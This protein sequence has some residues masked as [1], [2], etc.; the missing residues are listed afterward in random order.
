LPA[1]LPGSHAK[2]ATLQLDASYFDTPGGKLHKAGFMLRV[3][4]EGDSI[5]QT[6]KTGANGVGL[7][8]RAEWE[9][10]LKSMQPDLEA[11]RRTPM[12]PT[13]TAKTERLL[14]S[15][16][17]VRVNRRRWDVSRDGNLIEVTL[18]EGFIQAGNRSRPFNE[19]ELELKRGS[20]GA[21]FALCEE[22]SRRIPLRLGVLSKADRALEVA[23]DRARKPSKAVPI[24]LDVDVSIAEGFAMIALSCIQHFRLNEGAVVERRSAEGLHQLRVAIRRLRSSLAFFRPV[25][26][27]RGKY[28]RLDRQL[29]WLG[30]KLGEARNLDVFIALLDPKS[31][32][33]DQLRKA[34]ERS[35]DNIIAILNSRRFLSSM[36]GVVRWLT[37]GKWR[38]RRP[39]R[40][41]LRNFAAWRMEQAWTRLPGDGSLLLQMDERHRHRL[42]V[43]VK[44][45][46][47]VLESLWSVHEGPR[48]DRKAFHKRLE[49]LQDDLGRLNDIAIGERLAEE[50]G[51]C[52]L[53]SG[54]CADRD[55]LLAQ[56]AGNLTDLLAIG[57]YWQPL[58]RRKQPSFPCKP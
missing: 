11:A 6:V 53:K 20:E 10:P 35:Y 26:G 14:E 22:L 19:L 25:L 30:R 13:L 37:I 49:A 32:G 5:V 43:R 38:E 2:A 40:L 34:R 55:A 17:Q 18:D 7:F 41:S 12:G 15:F 39:A 44:R 48:R 29:V 45:L 31:R 36:I 56:A 46:R 23:R 24:A 9:T 4:R 57:P 33:L 3:R 52:L 58:G 47:Y 27:R 50:K 8:D 1:I 16:A 28:G 42:R 54:T 21:L 51:Y